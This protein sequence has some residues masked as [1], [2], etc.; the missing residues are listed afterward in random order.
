MNRLFQ[1]LLFVAIV[2]AA[3][4]LIWDS[5]GDGV[6]SQQAG[7]VL[8][9]TVST[10]FKKGS[11]AEPFFSRILDEGIPE[12]SPKQID[13]FV[14]SRHRSVGSLLGA[15][16]LTGD[17][18]WLEEAQT[19]YPDSPELA[20]AMIQRGQDGAS[21]AEW[22]ARLRKNDPGNAAGGLFAAKEALEAGDTTVAL[23][24]MES[25]SGSART[26][27]FGALIRENVGA[28]YRHAGHDGLIADW[29]GFT[30]SP[31]LGASLTGLN[32]A[33]ADAMEGAHAAGDDAQVEKL[34]QAGIDAALRM[35]GS[36]SDDHLIS[37]L[38]SVSMQRQVLGQLDTFDLIPG[39]QR[40]VVA[41]RLIELDQ[42]IGEIKSL[43]ATLP[44]RLE[45]MN[46]E[47][48]AEYTR[49][50]QSDGEYGALRWLIE[51][52]GTS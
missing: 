52:E 36:G 15:F 40:Q 28:A 27:F 45:I 26:D 50:L 43:T 22:I 44:D 37:R 30:R 3:F 24:E 7:K 12:L 2:M 21:R 4:W 10:G 48:V 47:D 16:F 29:A 19:S 42:E 31:V 5:G 1:I 8:S 33:I 34:G 14:D 6:N 18:S 38:I 46:D 41:D 49:R 51:R 32:K 13:S 23:A 35:R 20:V 9:R 25:L 17:E 39:D 11:D